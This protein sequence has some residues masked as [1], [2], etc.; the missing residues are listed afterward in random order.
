MTPQ[1][2]E[3]P[4]LSPETV[5]RSPSERYGFLFYLGI[6]GLIILLALIGWFGLALW[7]TRDLWRDVYRINDPRLPETARVEAAESLARDPRVTQAQLWDLCLSRVPPERARYVLAE[8]LDAEAIA[9]D[10]SAYALAVARSEGW[11]DWLRLLLVRPMAYDGGRYGLPREPLA[12]LRRHPDAGIQLWAAYTQAVARDDSEA[13]A[14]L[15]EQARSAAP[16]AALAGQLVQALE[17]SEP[18]GRR[19]R[20]DQATAWLRQHHPAALALWTQ[21]AG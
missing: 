8:A 18:E 1:F 21:P 4:I 6:G 20:L 2:P 11:P 12:E 19:Q 7:Q 16:E 15:R 13:A 9:G 17:A 14:W 5:R 3:L 10:P